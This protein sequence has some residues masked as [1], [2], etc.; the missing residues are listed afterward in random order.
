MANQTAL[1]VSQAKIMLGELDALAKTAD[2]LALEI[3]EF[4]RRVLHCLPAKYGS[5]FWWERGIA[6]SLKDYEEG[7]YKTFSSVKGLMKDLNS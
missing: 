5:D 7:R 2:R 1:T 3:S 6:E 4:K